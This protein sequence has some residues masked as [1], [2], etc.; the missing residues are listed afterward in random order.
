MLFSKN[1]LQKDYKG[2]LIIKKINFNKGFYNMSD[3]RNNIKDNIKL[4]QDKND[5]IIFASSSGKNGYFNNLVLLKLND[6]IIIQKSNVNFHYII[7]EIYL[8]KK[9]GNIKI[10][11]SKD[12]K[13]IVLTTDS[14]GKRGYQLI[15]IG[16]FVY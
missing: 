8:E 6:E 13:I 9:D 10:N 7:K 1:C 15:I 4:V 11:K 2:Y 3:K 5:A 16:I 14:P 12:E